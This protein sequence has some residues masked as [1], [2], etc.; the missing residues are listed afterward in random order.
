MKL[1]RPRTARPAFATTLV[2][3]AVLASLLPHYN[4]VMGLPHRGWSSSG[5][6]TDV[7]QGQTPAGR[8]GR[9]VRLRLTTEDGVAAVSLRGWVV[10]DGDIVF[11]V[12]AP[13]FSVP[14]FG[15]RNI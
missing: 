5:L 13:R 6:Q 12:Y 14:R 3:L 7:V 1:F 11:S 8:A 10:P 4:F 9:I 15:R 2:V